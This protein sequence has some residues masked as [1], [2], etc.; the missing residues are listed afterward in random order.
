[1]SNVFL[2]RER[3]ELQVLVSRWRLRCRYLLAAPFVYR[4]WWAMLTAN[5]RNSPVVLELRNGLKYQI[6]PRTGDV[7]VNNESMVLNP[8]LRP[9]YVTLTATST[10][11][12]VGANIGDFA[13]QTARLCPQGTIYA[14]EPVPEQCE[15]IK[16]Q[17]KLNSVSN[18][19]VIPLAVGSE[20]GEIELFVSG[21]QSSM[22][23]GTG[24]R[25]RVQVTTLDRIMEQHPIQRI[26]LLK[27]DCEGAEW[28]IF[29]L[30]ARVLPAVSQI[31]M[32]YHNGKRTAEWLEGWLVQHGF[33]VHRTPGP[34]C[35]LLWAWH[36]QSG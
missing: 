32:E 21:S 25:T 33:R 7:G 26:D 11:V 18:V 15:M 5:R 16:A 17:I 24:G 36:A 29:P 30:S 19:Q 9:G 22:Y 27:M 31:C 2:K 13:M 4:N 6:R 28:D 23:W 34:W 8:Y 20:N 10:V 3:W 12:D 1:M 35:G 14:I